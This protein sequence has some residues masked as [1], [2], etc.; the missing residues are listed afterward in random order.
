MNVKTETSIR[1]LRKYKKEELRKILDEY[2]ARCREVDERIEEIRRNRGTK[3]KPE[4]WNDY[5]EP[6]RSVEYDNLGRRLY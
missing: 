4:D 3:I 2:H 6:G 5:R 1:A